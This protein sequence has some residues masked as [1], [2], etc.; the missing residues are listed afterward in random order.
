MT[1]CKFEPKGVELEPSNGVF[2]DAPVDLVE[3][4]ND[5]G[6]SLLGV[7]VGPESLPP[8]EP[9][10]AVVILHGSG[11]LFS[12]P[13]RDDEL[14]EVSPQYADWAAMLSPRGHVVMLPSS[15]YS[16]GY[17]EWDDHPRDVDELERMIMRTYDAYGA[18]RF[19]C[20]QP[21]VDCERVALLGFSNGGSVTL[22]T[23]HEG[24][25]G[26]S[27][28]SQL[29][30]AEQRERFVRAVSYYPG[31]ELQGLAD[32]YFPAVLTTIEHASKDSLVEDCPGLFHQVDSTAQARAVDNPLTLTI[33]EGADHGF[34]GDPDNDAEVRARD[35]ARASTLDA[36]EQA[37]MR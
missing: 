34:D 9:M 4:D 7:L 17:F 30:P 14:L 36:F 31:C 20:E 12:T 8:P 35:E 33:H 28:M 24:L 32:D 5:R 23:M 25:D 10:P 27:G 21:F 13:D 19:L 18:L 26:V 2:L 37:L 11:G 1:G 6:E 29:T 3:F 15:F 16:R 22:M